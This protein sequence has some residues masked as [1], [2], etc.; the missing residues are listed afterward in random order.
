MS[1]IS[2]VQSFNNSNV[3]FKGIPNQN[4]K[5]TSKEKKILNDYMRKTLLQSYK[6]SQKIEFFQK[7]ML[8]IYQRI[9]NASV[10]I[11]KIFHKI[12]K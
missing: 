10:K 8:P 5:L 2:S 3:Q 7:Y 6:D 1:N 12:L 9:A 4:R 11:E